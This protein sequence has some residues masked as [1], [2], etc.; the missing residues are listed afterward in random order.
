MKSGNW[1]Q[2]LSCSP[3]RGPEMAARTAISC[4]RRRGPGVAIHCASEGNWGQMS[5]RMGEALAKSSDWE[6]APFRARQPNWVLRRPLQSAVLA[7]R[8]V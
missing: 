2:T 7:L 3:S 8:S 4:H 1:Y 5:L 6:G